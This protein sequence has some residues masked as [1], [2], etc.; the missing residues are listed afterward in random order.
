LAREVGTVEIPERRRLRGGG[1]RRDHRRPGRSGRRREWGDAGARQR[2][3]RTKVTTRESTSAASTRHPAR[4][5]VRAWGRSLLSHQTRCSY[6]S[7]GG[8]ASGAGQ[9][10][11]LPLGCRV[12]PGLREG[13]FGRPGGPGAG[14]RGAAITAVA[15]AQAAGV[16]VV[17]V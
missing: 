9:R 2:S 10:R 11:G 6:A 14:R 4:R 15:V 5:H 12:P 8:E 16:L 3:S 1:L 17:A 13:P 7:S